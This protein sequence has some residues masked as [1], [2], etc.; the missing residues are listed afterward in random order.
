MGSVIQDQLY[1]VFVAI[2]GER[3]TS[4]DTMID[5]SEQLARSVSEAGKAIQ[6][7]PA[8]IAKQP[9]QAGGDAAAIASVFEGG[10]LVNALEDIRNASSAPAAGNASA[11]STAGSIASSLVS[12]VFGGI[13]LVSGIQSTQ[14]AAG[15]GGIGSVVESIASTVLKSG[16]GMLPLVGGLLG[17]FGGGGSSDPPPLVKYAMPPSLS[18]QGAEVGAGLGNSDYD[19]D[20]MPRT[21]GGSGTAGGGTVPSTPAGPRITVNVQAMDAR[22]FL[23]RSGEIAAAVREAML[24]LNS[25][26][27]VVND[28]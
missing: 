22:S 14:T 21:Y 18:F 10:P 5:A 8:T 24:N 1:E 11:S 28:L 27:D 12:S 6:A 13:P 19:Q 25:I 16:F 17:L 4:Q 9:I 23:D 20:G 15:S 3:A 2:S 26:N 7:T